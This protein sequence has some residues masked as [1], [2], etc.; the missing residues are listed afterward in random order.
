[1]SIFTKFGIIV[2]LS[3]WAQFSFAQTEKKIE[4]SAIYLSDTDNL[5][6]IKTIAV[7]PSSD[8]VDG[9]YARPLEEELKEIIKKSHRFQLSSTQFTGAVQTPEELEQNPDLVS[10]LSQNLEGEALIASRAYKTANTL[11][12]HMSLF[13][14]K[15]GKT[16]SREIIKESKSFDLA[17]LKSIASEAYKTLIKTL[18]YDGVIMSRSGSLVTVNLGKKDGIRPGQILTAVLIINLQRH[19]KLNFIINTEKEVL[20][21]IKIQKVDETLS[22]GD[23]ISEKDIGTIQKGNKIAGVEFVTYSE[24]SQINPQSLQKDTK[25]PIAFGESPKEWKP[26]DPPVFGKVGLSL[27]FGQM[28]YNTKLQSA[29]S[30][31]GESNFYPTFLLTG[32]LWMTQNWLADIEIEQGVATIKNPYPS[33]SPSDLSANISNFALSFGYNFLIQDDFFGPSVLLSLGYGSYGLDVDS[34]SPLGLTSTRYKGFF[35]GIKG[36]MPV[37]DD[38][39]WNAGVG[40]QYFLKSDLSESPQGS[41]SPDNTITRFSLLGFYQKNSRLR[42]TGALDFSLYSTSF[43]GSGTRPDPADDASQKYTVLRGGIEYLF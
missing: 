10:S 17:R 2:L 40:L 25:D 42:F 21:K 16:I 13:L 29:G 41:G 26:S 4:T 7:L 24:N 8:N 15:D 31:N 19:P 34:S 27:G 38:Q 43:S 35:L 30:L 14:K 22:F 28:R 20:G 5:V 1:M 11:T 37:S 39:R 32:Q 23:I 9:I 36:L 33:S 18:P 12:V 6:S 3:L